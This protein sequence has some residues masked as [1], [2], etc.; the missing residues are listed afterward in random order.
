MCRSCALKCFN[1]A[2]AERIKPHGI[3]EG[4]GNIDDS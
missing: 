1:A 2:K 3:S 4:E